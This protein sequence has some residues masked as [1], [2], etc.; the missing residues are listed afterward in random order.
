MLEEKVKETYQ[1]IEEYK[2]LIAQIEKDLAV[3]DRNINKD[4]LLESD[5]KHELAVVTAEVS[6]IESKIPEYEDLIKDLE[7]TKSHLVD[8]KTR[9]KMDM[10]LLFCLR[11]DEP[12][13]E[14][15]PQTDDVDWE[16]D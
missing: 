11:H 1:S 8:L 13:R 16:D 6:K 10:N 3:T 14:N 12:K 15:Y 9:I 5:L 2:R 7:R 4:E